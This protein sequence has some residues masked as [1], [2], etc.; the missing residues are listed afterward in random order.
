MTDGLNPDDYDITVGSPSP[1]VIDGTVDSISDV[2][3]PEGEFEL[4]RAHL[5]AEYDG[6]SARNFAVRDLDR[7]GP[8]RYVV[9]FHRFTGGAAM[10]Q[11]EYIAIAVWNADREAWD[12]PE[13]ERVLHTSWH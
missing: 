5:V 4:L 9:S 3:L 1:S 8:G 10:W 2:S 11:D 13:V 7:L 12:L 6:D